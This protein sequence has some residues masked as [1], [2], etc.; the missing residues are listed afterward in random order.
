MKT[1]GADKQEGV[2]RIRKKEQLYFI[3]IIPPQPIYDEAL[4]LK[5]YFESNYK[6]KAA[7]NSPPHI[8]L[9]MPFM[10][11]EEKEHKLISGLESFAAQHFCF[12]LQLKDFN[13]FKP[14]VIYIDVIENEELK[15]LQGILTKFCKTEF[16]LF[17]ANRLDQPF[18]PHLTL[19]F[20][21]LRK[22]MFNKA[23][24]EFQDKNFEGS[25]KVDTITLLKHDGTKWN[26]LNSFSLQ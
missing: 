2:A 21:D 4:N 23:W 5:H 12:D 18:H 9:H 14:R 19:A 17:N 13:C 6:S 20:R 3:G 7:L 22:A 25:W 11:K 8:T 16:N 26:A 10:W 15:A 1:Q 24:E